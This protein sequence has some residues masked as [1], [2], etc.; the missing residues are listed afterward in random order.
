M[1]TPG[2][3]DVAMRKIIQD[4]IASQ[5]A[6]VTYVSPS[7]ARAASAGTYILYASHIAAMAP[8]TNLGAATPV[9]IGGGSPA[10][11]R[12]PDKP[13]KDKKDK[14]EKPEL[15]GDA[16]THKQVNDAIAYIRSLAQM[17]GRNIEWAEKA[18]R[19][20]ASLPADEA[21][22]Q[23]VVDLVAK[24]LDDLLA[25]IN[26]RKVNVLGQTVALDTK[27]IKIEHIEPD[28]RSRLLAVITDP[29]V[30]YILMLLGVYGLFFELWN[31]GYVLPGVV[32]GISLLLALYAFQVLPVN[33]AGFGLIILGMAF[34]IAEAF[35]P[36]FGVLGFGG[37]LAFV[38]GSVILLDTDAAGF[39]ISWPL[40]A[41]VALISAAFF[42]TVVGLALNARKRPVVT[43]KEELIGRIAEATASFKNE[44]RVRVR[45]ED[46][47]ARTEHP[48]QRGQRVRIIGMEG[49]T[50]IVEPETETQMEKN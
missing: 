42:V 24:N 41:T 19:E 45:G 13:K 29:N 9:Q 50:L 6:V 18:V 16:M 5:V 39:G 3:L 4:I 49:L 27:D 36:S 37:V 15:G 26:G 2:G 46:W 48:V 35:M 12:S 31:P 20:A 28:W 1:D 47:Q 21:V 10:P 11:D 30:A 14:A 25:K 8:G 40:I 32:G 17:R 22:K 23:D 7:G 38:A 34:M 33:Y 43:G 44:G